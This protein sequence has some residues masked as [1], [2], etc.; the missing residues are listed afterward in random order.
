M[1]SDRQYRVAGIR[2]WLGLLSVIACALHAQPVRAQG[3]QDKHHLRAQ[4]GNQFHADVEVDRFDSHAA[5]L[6][7]EGVGGVDPSFFVHQA[8]V[9]SDSGVLAISSTFSLQ[10]GPEAPILVAGSN[11]SSASI[12]ESIDP[13]NSP[14]G[15][16]IVTAQLRWGGSGSLASSGDTD[17]G[18]VSAGLAVNNCS[19]GYTKGF[20]STGVAS[21]DGSDFCSQTFYVTSIGQA[22]AGLL[23]VTQIIAEPTAIPNR[24]YV[25][26]SISGEAA[27]N[28]SLEYFDSGQYEASGQ[29]SIHV[30]GVDFTYSS[31]TF[32]TLP[33]PGDA[34]VAATAIAVLSMLA[35]R[36]PSVIA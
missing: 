26:A 2:A 4:A 21:N 35:R 18:S 5:F 10:G 6:W 33:E 11:A 36:R 32:L 29:L 16:V 23:K 12:E 15:P 14:T 1:Q 19:V 31:P 7:Q 27:S 20:S 3:T 34:V 9:D 25:T 24:F 28:T 30:S 22:S 17:I 13:G 8:T